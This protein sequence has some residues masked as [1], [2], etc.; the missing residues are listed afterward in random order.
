MKRVI[1]EVFRHNQRNL[2]GLDVLIRPQRALSHNDA[3]G[4]VEELQLLLTAIV[5]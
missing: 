1:R 3:G 5:R 4:A 2:A